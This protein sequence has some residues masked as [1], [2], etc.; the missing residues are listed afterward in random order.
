[1]SRCGLHDRVRRPLE[2]DPQARP[3]RLDLADSVEHAEVL[4]VGRRREVQLQATHRDPLQ[5]LD[6]V[7]DDEPSGAEDRHPV[8]DAVDLGQGVRG[9]EH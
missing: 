5:V 8:R 2:G 4:G 3:G 1:V 6:R 7:H 9:E